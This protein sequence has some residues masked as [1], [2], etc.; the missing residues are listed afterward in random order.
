MK[1][2]FLCILAILVCCA[3][4]SQLKKKSQAQCTSTPG[5]FINWGRNQPLSLVDKTNGIYSSELRI[6]SQ[7]DWQNWQTWCLER[8]YMGYRLISP[9][10]GLCVRVEMFPSSDVYVYASYECD[11][12]FSRVVSPKNS[13]YFSYGLNINGQTLYLTAAEAGDDSL[14]MEVL[15]TGSSNA[16]QRKRRFQEW[17]FHLP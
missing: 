9:Y 4:G 17:N 13:L 11:T 6:D 7:T 1:K 14:Y 3:S 12:Y 16:Q 15:E 2:L 5:N 10:N 8:T